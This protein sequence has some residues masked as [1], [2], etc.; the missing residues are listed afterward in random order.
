MVIL[1]FTGTPNASLSVGDSIYTLPNTINYDGVDPF[2][3]GDSF[4]STFGTQTSYILLGT[5]NS[6]VVNST[7]FDLH[8]ESD[9]ETSI[10]E[11]SWEFTPN[12]GDFILF[13]KNNQVE[14][15]SII[16]YYNKIRLRNDSNR[17][18]ELF[19]VSVDVA[20]SSK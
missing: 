10:W 15:S 11:S 9:N 3:S 17:K 8:I 14:L 5:V 13:S 20:Q 2:L 1:N 6:I 19:A 16:G 18:V 12:S 7:G 4:S